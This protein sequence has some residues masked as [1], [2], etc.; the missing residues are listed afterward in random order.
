[1]ASIEMKP[2]FSIIVPVYNVEKYLNRCIDSILS[3]TFEDFEVLLI[4]DGSNDKSGAICD[5]YAKSDNRVRVFHKE[6]GGVSSARNVGLDNAC[7]EWALFVDSDDNVNRYYLSKFHQDSD[8]EIQGA[9]TINS[10][11]DI[12]EGELKYN[13]AVLEIRCAEDAILRDLNTAPWAKCFRKS[14]ID[15][16]N[17]R[18]DEDLSYGEDSIFIYEYLCFCS[19]IRY[20]SSVGYKYYIFDTGLGH[21][22]HPIEKIV[23]M[24]AKQFELYH[25]ILNDSNKQ[26]MFFHR[27]T[28]FALR[29]F[30]LWYHVSY[31][32]LRQHS[33]VDKIVKMHLNLLEKMMLYFPK[34]YL[35]YCSFYYKY[36]IR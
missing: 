26:Q 20:N 32:K 8:M 2:T 29:E 27:K 14:I 16:N 21:K 13:D 33:F 7:G 19:T 35:N 5:E 17:I 31:R 25:K 30:F 36:V 23:S 4:D 12:K 9:V 28:L 22:R 11:S 6:N 15:T 10:A 1:M 34:I 3:Q 24:Y 18:F